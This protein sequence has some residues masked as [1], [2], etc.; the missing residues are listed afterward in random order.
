MSQAGPR[1]TVPETR[2]FYWSKIEREIQRPEAQTSRAPGVSWFGILCRRVLPAGFVAALLVAGLLVYRL[3]APPPAPTTVADADE[4]TVETT[5][6]NSDA[7]TYRDAS[8]DTTL[9]WF[10]YADAGPAQ[11]KTPSAVN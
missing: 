1:W 9:V 6:A 7:T 10:S 3:N 4:P 11:L 8:G 2:E 5:L